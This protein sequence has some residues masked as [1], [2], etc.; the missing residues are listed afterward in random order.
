LENT[1]AEIISG[2]VFGADRMDYLLRD[3]LYTGVVTGHVDHLRLIDSIRILPQIAGPGDSNSPSTG[4]PCL[5]IK[6]GGLHAAE[7]L[8]LSRYF[9]FAQVYHHSVRRIYDIHL[10]QFM[11]QWLPGGKYPT[12]QPGHL[13][14]NDNTVLEAIR[15]AASDVSKAGHEAA[16]RIQER[17]HFKTVYTL[18]ATDA[19]K[20]PN[21]I[22]ELAS[23]IEKEFDKNDF[24][25]V[26]EDPPK[27]KGKHDFPVELQDK[28]VVSAFSESH[29]LE[30]VPV[31]RPGFIF[32]K[33][34][35]VA[36]MKELC[37]NYLQHSGERHEPV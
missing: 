37:D 23:E 13:S 29:I 1:L 3:S 6:K 5:G 4:E 12:D 24:V 30:H 8:L 31:P 32:G 28:R 14:M 16:R 36:R 18:S 25:V 21:I 7:A 17:D 15:E 10:G 9:M 27:D 34:E 20:K 26:P 33:P 22:K 35:H 2:D 19:G 11:K